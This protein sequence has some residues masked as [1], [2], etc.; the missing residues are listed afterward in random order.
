MAKNKN[1]FSVAAGLFD[2]D[3]DTS[4]QISQNINEQDLNTPIA[5]LTGTQGRKG[6]K[7]RSMNIPVTDEEYEAIRR[8]SRA[9]GM[10]YGEYVYAAVTFYQANGGGKL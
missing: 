9:A 4:S 3:E 5:Q 10:T 8:G 2:K 7:L 1:S 6:A